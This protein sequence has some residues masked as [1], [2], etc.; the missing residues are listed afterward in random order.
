M[1][2]FGIVLVLMVL[3]VVCV[4]YLVGME[5]IDSLIGAWDTAQT[6]LSHVTS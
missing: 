3:A 5:F 4:L 2:A 1:I 6:A